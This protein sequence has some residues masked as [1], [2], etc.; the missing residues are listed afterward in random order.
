[1]VATI[2]RRGPTDG[3]LDALRAGMRT[4]PAHPDVAPGLEGLHGRRIPPRHPYPL[5]IAPTSPS[6]LD[7]AGLGEFFEHQFTVD[8][9]R[10]VQAVD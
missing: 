3:D 8:S 4:M 7:N 5:S 1:M 9:A 6:P 2:A 10:G